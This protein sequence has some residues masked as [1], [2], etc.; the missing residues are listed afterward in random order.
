MTG[1]GPVR[2]PRIGVQLPTTDGFLVGYGDLRRVASTAEELGFDGLWVG[3]HF[4]FN[5]P[6]LEAVVA[7]STVAAVTEH[8]TIGF[9]VLIAALRHPG[10]VA[11][12]LSSLQVVSRDRVELGV[13]VGGEFAGEWAAVGVPVSERG[14]RTDEFLRHLPALLT[15]QAADLGP[16]WQAHIPPLQPHGVVPPLWIG[17]RGDVSL[18]RAVRHGAG[19]LGVWVDEARVATATG[20][21]AELAEEAGVEPPRVGFEVLVHPEADVDHGHAQMA[22]FM[23]QIYGIPYERVSKYTIA[24]DEDRIIERL[25][26]IVDLGVDTIVLIP[27]VRDPLSVL[28]ALSRIA[29]GLRVMRRPV[30]G[31]SAAA[32]SRCR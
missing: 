14:T 29:Q 26:P 28:P 25:Q 8:V 1:S 20:R 6:V 11:K 22:S 10:W 19:W 4:S 5:A 18:R 17:G 13:G 3:D 7:A 27:A 21:L 31:G 32:A 23:E 9:G 2:S 15:G 16:P 12:Q 24:G 30:G